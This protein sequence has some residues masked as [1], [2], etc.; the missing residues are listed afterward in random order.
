MSPTF[1]G[2]IPSLPRVG[3]ATDKPG[4]KADLERKKRGN[5]P[6]R[7]LQFSQFGSGR[8]GRLLRIGGRGWAGL[9]C[10]A[11]CMTSDFE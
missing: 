6:L 8:R 4:E 10:G 7:T 2:G 1:L 3:F 5:S 11:C 9:Y